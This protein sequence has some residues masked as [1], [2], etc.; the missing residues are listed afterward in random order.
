MLS[1]ILLFYLSSIVLF[2]LPLKKLIIINKLSLDIL[3]FIISNIIL[4]IAVF[5]FY[6][7]F[8]DLTF[9]LI[10]DIFLIFNTLFYLKEIISFNKNFIYYIIPYFLSNIIFLLYPILKYLNIL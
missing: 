4:I 3:F 9:T 1:L 7:Y 10:L 8:H 2:H 6:F 5:I